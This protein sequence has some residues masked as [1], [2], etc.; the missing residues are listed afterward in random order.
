MQLLG[1]PP[2]T[3]TIEDAMPTIFVIFGFRFM[4]Y[5]NDHTP[6][7]VHVV[8]GGAHAK[9]TLFPVEP[10]SNEGLKPSELRMV[11]AIIEEN[12]DRIAEHW[13]MFFNTIR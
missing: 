5:S 10:V 12:R 7:H 6:I 1:W 11:R 3:E 9:F 2:C 4:F 8:K 13:N